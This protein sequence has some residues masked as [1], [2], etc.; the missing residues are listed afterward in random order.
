MSD[1]ILWDR[2]SDSHGY[3]HHWDNERQRVVKAHRTAYEAFWGPI[4]EGMYVMHTCDTPACYNPLHLVAG[5][6]ADNMR[7][8]YAK[9]RQGR[10][11]DKAA[12]CLRGHPYDEEN[13]RVYGGRQFCR[14]CDRDRRRKRA[15]SD[16]R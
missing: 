5:T 14:E 8:M 15:S 3:G 6:H 2:A 16:H 13:T 9:G 12:S 7:D 10:R 1:C 4:P 11:R